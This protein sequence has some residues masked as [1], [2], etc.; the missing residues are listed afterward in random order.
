MATP[1]ELTLRALGD[2]PFIQKGDDLT[3]VILTAVAANGL[4][5]Q[6]GDVV[7]LAL[8]IAGVLGADFDL[9]GDAR[10]V[11]ARADAGDLDQGYL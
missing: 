6:S 4:T 1:A 8:Q 10:I 9:L 2:V 3:E 7:L 11:H 5:L